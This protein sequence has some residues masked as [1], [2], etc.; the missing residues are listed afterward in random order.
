MAIRK[1]T[2]IIVGGGPVG[3]TA[4]LGLTRAGIDFI[5]LE[6]RKTIIVEEGSDMTLLPMTMRALDQM[7]LLEPLSRIWNPVSEI[8]RIDHNGRGI[9]ELRVFRYIKEWSVYRPPD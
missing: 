7:N 4:A 9:G 1:P 6:Q 2:V 8:G 3:L 5:L